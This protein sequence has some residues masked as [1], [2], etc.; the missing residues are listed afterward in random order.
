MGEPQY[1]PSTIVGGT[2]T[3][4]DGAEQQNGDAAL[5]GSVGGLAD[6][7]TL[8]EILRLQPFG[9]TVTKAVLPYDVSGSL[10]VQFAG[11]V[12]PTRSANGSVLVYPFRA[13]I[14]SRTSTS[15]TISVALQNWRDIRTGVFTG[16]SGQQTLALAA[17][18]SGNPRWDLV[19]A[20]FAVDTPSNQVQRRIKDPSSGAQSVQSVYQY[21]AQAIT[22]SVLQGTPAATPAIPSA[23]SDSGTTYNIPLAAVRVINGFGPTSTVLASDIRDQSPFVP[24]SKSTGSTSI[25]PAAGNNDIGGT[26][27]VDTTFQWPVT[28][29]ANRPGVFLP[30]SWVGAEEI[31]VHIDARTS[32]HPSHPSGDVV[33]ASVDWSNR[34]FW[35]MACFGQHPFWS[36]PSLASTTQ[37]TPNAVDFAIPGSF[38]A[39]NV[40]VVGPANSTYQDG[41]IVS[42]TSTICV[43]NSGRYSLFPAGTGLG[44]YVNSAGQ[45]LSFVQGNPNLALF[46]WIRASAPFPNFHT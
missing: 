9:G 10:Q 3:L 8:A 21:L 17:N 15:S 38:S 46:A 32:G 12:Q 22:V 43:G 42:G 25:R 20:S 7:R 44:L 5:M 33:D 45:L 35:V 40:V 30:P 36:D 37:C 27:A 23:P 1:Y 11:T 41:F 6:D 16:P 14:G 31:I 2:P 24:I 39:G 29:G 34:V 18:S 4:V 26:Y 28:S 19:Y 13:V